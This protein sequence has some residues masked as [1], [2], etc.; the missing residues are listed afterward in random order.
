M[1]ITL[2]NGHTPRILEMPTSHPNRFLG[3]YAV[4]WDELDAEGHEIITYGFATS[5][6]AERAIL[7]LY[8]EQLGQANEY[9][10]DSADNGG[11]E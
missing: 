10:R 8:A 7:D 9:A 3:A 4:L 5:A 6:A 1:S 2:L 11:Q